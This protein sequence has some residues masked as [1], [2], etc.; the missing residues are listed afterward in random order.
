MPGSHVMRSLSIVLALAAWPL[1]V[2]AA[3]APA[4]EADEAEAR[5]ADAQQPL[6]ERP[7][8]PLGNRPGFGGPGSEGQ[9][10]PGYGGPG[11]GSGGGRG[12]GGRGGFGGFGGYRAPDQVPDNPIEKGY[13]FLDGQYLAPPYKLRLVENGVTVNGRPLP[14]RPPEDFG[15]GYGGYDGPHSDPWRRLAAQVATQLSS[16]CVILAFSDQ[17][18]VVLDSSSGAYD[19]FQRLTGEGENPSN[20]ALV[21]RLPDGFDQS[22]WNS[23]VRSFTPSLGLKARAVSFISTFDESDA[24]ARAEVSAR[25]WLNWLA[26]PLTLGG[27]VLTVLSIG[28]LLGGRPLAGKTP[29]EQDTSPETLRALQYSLVL[30]GLL[31]LLDLAWTIMAAQSGQMRELNPFGS[32]LIESPSLLALFK[33][34]ATGMAIGLLFSL[35]KYRRAQVAAWW[36]C[37]ILTILAFRWLTFN[38]MM[39]SA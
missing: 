36:A 11:Y 22:V 6:V 38:S 7:P 20:I 25:R 28:H 27:M 2:Q 1:V 31:S 34:T 15:R 12:Y 24:D 13:L 19:L 30:V 39:L 14:C 8:Q 10:G 9:G 33:I 16:E 29:H 32:K 4:P 21:D 5:T 35:R 26:Y 17:P 18:L 3:P 37:L 23:W